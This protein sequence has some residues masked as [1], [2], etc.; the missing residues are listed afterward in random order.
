MNILNGTGQTMA[1]FKPKL[2]ACCLN[3]PILRVVV[4]DWL[5]EICVIGKHNADESPGDF[6]GIDHSK[7]IVHVVYFTVT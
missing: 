6:Y 2:V 7:G 4:C 3:G 5:H 1:C